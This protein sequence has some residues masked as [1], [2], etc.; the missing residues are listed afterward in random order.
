MLRWVIELDSLLLPPNDSLW[1]IYSITRRPPVFDTEGNVYSTLTMSYHGF[2]TNYLICIDASGN[3]LWKTNIYGAFDDR[4][5]SKPVI[6]N[7]Q[8]YIANGR[9]I[10][11]L[12]KD[13]EILRKN[14]FSPG[15]YLWFVEDML[16]NE[17]GYLYAI[18][19]NPTPDWRLH[20][21]DSTLSLA[22]MR[23]IC[24]FDEYG[25]DKL[26]MDA[27]GNIYFPS[28]FPFD[29][30]LCSLDKR[31][32]LRWTFPGIYPPYV[33]DGNNTIHVVSADTLISIYQDGRIKS[34]IIIPAT[35]ASP[36][37]IGNKGVIYFTS[38]DSILHAVATSGV[39]KWTYPIDGSVGRSPTLDRFGN[40]YVLT[41]DGLLYSIQTE[42]DSLDLNGFPKKFY[43]ARNS[44]FMPNRP[45]PRPEINDPRPEINVSLTEIDFG[46][47]DIGQNKEISFTITNTGTDT[48]EITDM[49]IASDA[50]TVVDFTAPMRILP[51]DVQYI[52]IKYCP[53]ALGIITGKLRIYNNT[54]ENPVVISLKGVG[55]TENRLHHELIVYPNPFLYHTRIEFCV[56]GDSR[57]KVIIFDMRGQ[58][59]KTFLGKSGGACLNSI[60]WDGRDHSGRPVM[61]GIYFCKL[62]I[63]EKQTHSEKII[64]IK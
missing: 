25:R 9:S 63:D 36:M 1:R 41:N 3:I 30:F 24:G 4:A 52:T 62:M 45:Y 14:D 40:L 13:G 56:F 64:L 47:V 5:A 31:G 48:L 32:D 57:A 59:V 2:S 7:S 6:G 8:I 35:R 15:Y 54:R 50:F 29:I 23:Y 22:W 43:D 46:E 44:G 12:S 27:D 33:I 61:S 60:V 26:L 58:E 20:A 11:H 34:K 38:S 37:C 28:G 19:Y 21:V 10:M 53:N 16:K 55:S 49:V 17:L 18:Q 39:V 51:D 42:S